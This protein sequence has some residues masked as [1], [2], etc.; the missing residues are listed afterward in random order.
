MST[1]PTVASLLNGHPVEDGPGG[2]LRIQNPTHLDEAVAEA[3]LG[4]ATTFLEACREAKAAQPGWAAIPAPT[5]GRAI[6][7]LGRLVEENFEALSQLIT[8]EI[9]KPIREARGEVQEVVD[10]CNFFLGEGRRLYGQTVPSEMPDKQLFT[11][12]TPV[13]AAAIVTAGNFPVAVPSWYIVPALVCGN[14]IVWKP[15]EYT[16]ATAVAFAQLILHSGIPTG[17]FQLVLV[18]GP[19]AFQGIERALDE[20][21]LDKVGFTGSSEVG[22]RIGEL[23]G[24]HLQS[25]CLELGG[26]NP[27]VVMPD[28]DLDLAV[29]GALFSGFGTAGQRCT[30]LGTA[31]VHRDVHDDFMARFS[32]AVMDAPIGDPTRDVLYGPMISARFCDRFERW[33]E[34]IRPH[35]S[36]AGSD[37][38]GRITSANPRTGF[39]GDPEAGLFYHPVIVGGVTIDDDL[40]R[41][42]TFG[43]IVGVASFDTF[44]QAMELANA[45]GYG[46]SSSI[47]TNDP[48]HVFHFRDRISA[49]M[50]SVNNSTSGAEAHLPFGG[51]GRSGNGSRQSGLWVLDQFTRWQAMNWDYSGHLQ[52][53]Q[54]DTEELDVVPGF[55]LAAGD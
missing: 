11:F 34:L 9:G 3:R 44:D 6:Q 51:N 1:I 2:T 10:T 21:V 16:P 39:V 25:P 36:V 50:V 40:Y 53:A 8:R 47:Y 18:E 12:R 22:R 26:K 30:S 13:G 20:Q 48:L 24:R 15:A 29:E 43:P 14:T 46:L 37:G 4:D 38:I 42:E 52:K 45:H 27:L 5:R 31:I 7:H 17:V 55:R 23:C 33:L 54:M 49:G 35:H 28:A 19:R 32:K 41:T